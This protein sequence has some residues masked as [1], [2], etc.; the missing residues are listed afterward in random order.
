V[1]NW[2]YRAVYRTP[3]TFALAT[4]NIIVLAVALSVA[5]GLVAG[6]AAAQPLVRTPPLVLLSGHRN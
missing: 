1:I 2:H 3:L 5:R 6:F 4:P